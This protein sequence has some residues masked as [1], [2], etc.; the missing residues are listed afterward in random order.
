LIINISYWA[1]QKYMN[2]VMYG[3]SKAATDRLA[4]DMA[5]ELRNYQV[6]AISLYPGLVRTERVL[7]V[8]GVFDLS[9]SESPQFI[10]RAV[11]A[12]AADSN[13]MQKSGQVLVAAALAL[14]YGFKDIDGKQP[15][16]LSL[17]DS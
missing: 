8:A 10:G 14:E 3:V 5:H 4:V 13:I 17:Q 6:A 9:N 12:L 15:K 16:P 1:G 11:A 7:A 2:N